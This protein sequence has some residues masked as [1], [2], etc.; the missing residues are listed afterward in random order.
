MQGNIE[1]FQVEKEQEY[2][3]VVSVLPLQAARP[4]E[5][6]A[7]SEVLPPEDIW[8]TR[9]V[10]IVK[11]GGARNPYEVMPVRG[12]AFAVKTAE[13]AP[14][15]LRR[16]LQI[17]VFSYGASQEYVRRYQFADPDSSVLVGREERTVCIY[18]RDILPPIGA[19]PDDKIERPILL[20]PNELQNLLKN[21]GTSIQDRWCPLLSSLQLDNGQP[22]DGIH[23]EPNSINELREYIMNNAYWFEV[24]IRI[25][26]L[27]ELLKEHAKYSA[28]LSHHQLDAISKL[29]SLT[30][31]TYDDFALAV[32]GMME[33]EIPQNPLGLLNY[34][35]QFYEAFKRNP[36]FGEDYQNA[37]A[38]VHF[39]DMIS[40]PAK[41]TQKPFFDA[42]AL[43]AQEKILPE[44]IVSIADLSPY[45]QEIL[46]C[47]ADALD[48]DFFDR[49]TLPE[50]TSA[51][52]AVLND[53]PRRQEALARLTESL[54]GDTVSDIQSKAE[55][56][57][58]FTKAQRNLRTC[59]EA[60]SELIES[61]VE[62]LRPL[63]NEEELMPLLS[64]PFLYETDLLTLL[65]YAL[66]LQAAHE[67]VDSESGLDPKQ[68]QYLALRR[69]L[70]L[71]YA[72]KASADYY[73]KRN[74]IPPAL[75]LIKEAVESA[76]MSAGEEEAIKVSIKESVKTF[77]RKNEPARK[78]IKVL[79]ESSVKTL[80]SFIRKMLERTVPRDILDVNRITLTAGT[81]DKEAGVRVLR[82]VLER[83]IGAMIARG[84]PV[85]VSNIKAHPVLL[86]MIHELLDS[87]G[88]KIEVTKQHAGSEATGLKGVYWGKLVVTSGGVPLE[89]ALAATEEDK[90]AK[91]ADDAEF[92]L[93][94]LFT[95]EFSI[96]DALF[97]HVPQLRE[98]LVKYHFSRGAGKP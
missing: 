14:R 44:M 39:R 22:A 16:E 97:A 40:V 79:I 37:Y 63:Y 13:D 75:S 48:I 80:P 49:Y 65:S 98:D 94:R 81:S 26:T 61:V 86:N 43:T 91:Q 32:G 17:P 2:V 23:A 69:L 60:A 52:R 85:A 66:E 72:Q 4:Q 12:K 38:I 64:D 47:A 5:V 71:M 27:A 21:N 93:R 25:A 67:G 10:L 15:I 31:G 96:V 11:N 73:E 30:E 59:A 55:Q 6:F 29:V 1:G 9:T 89:I 57:R 50:L 51:L 24:K 8:L 35:N 83:V 88:D 41:V 70:L 87:Y 45:L 18:L 54:F 20:T 7:G 46:V 77:W 95:G 42:I 3:P 90:N 34:I 56:E 28:E 36:S 58:Q 62:T 68:L 33:D 76:W 92:Q 53:P 78:A 82:D 84:M 74:T 19:H